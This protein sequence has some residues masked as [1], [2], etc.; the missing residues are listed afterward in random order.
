MFLEYLSSKYV[1][2]AK[3]L[4][5]YIS[6]Q[7]L[8]QIITFASGILLIHF[9]N[10]QEYAFFTLATS[11]Q[12]VMI[13]LSDMGIDSSLLAIGGKVW[14]DKYR[15][16]QLINTA[17]R[18]RSYLAIICSIVIT[19]IFLWMLI[20]NGAS[21][22]YAILMLVTIAVGLYFILA[23]RILNIVPR[24]NS[25]IQ[26]V[27]GL[28][29][30]FAS[31][32]LLILG[33]AY[34]TYM[35]AGVALFATTISFA[36]QRVLI[37]NWVQRYIDLKAPTFYQDQTE[38]LKNIKSCFPTTI[39][40]CVQGQITIWLISLFGNTQNIAE[41]G[42]LGRLEVLFALIVSMTDNIL[43]PRFARCQ[44]RHELIKLYFKILGLTIILEIF[45]IVATLLFP[46][47]ILWLLGGKYYNLQDVI[48]L[49]TIGAA[50]RNT[51]STI[52]SM[53][54]SK[55]W[56]KD[57]WVIIPITLVWQGILLLFLNISTVRGVI[58]FGIMTNIP[59][60]LFYL[61]LS[62]RGFKQ[63]AQSE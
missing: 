54:N 16:G 13:I 8:I 44:S 46:S 4:S 30:C 59:Y 2:W 42:A 5:K 28:E 19:P 24:L 45:I 20:D 51:V 11:M 14:Q 3:Y 29:F 48:L 58:W 23:T 25:K 47:Q 37:N 53:N 26:Q 38:I 18:L 17:M 52:L 31:F 39:F 9:L 35:N 32:R 41:I 1:K 12:T 49:M 62:Y 27:Q 63:L 57:G 61:F 43:S 55:A 10:K 50:L 56:L 40:F 60:L 15:F 36:F 6:I 21:I 22:R 34:F 7:L 33:V